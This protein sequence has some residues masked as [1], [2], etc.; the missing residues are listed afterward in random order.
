MSRAKQ[1]VTEWG[2]LSAAQ[3]E[4]LGAL[5]D[6]R[7][8]LLGEPYGVAHDRC[9]PETISDANRAYVLGEEVAR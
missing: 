9:M 5:I 1:Q 2:D 7:V 6:S 3:Q 4:R 8:R